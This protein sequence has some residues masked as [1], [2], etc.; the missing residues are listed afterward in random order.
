MANNCWNKVTIT[1]SNETLNKIKDRFESSE[2]GI[3]NINN[4]HILF[5]SDVSDMDEDDF[6][7][8]WFTPSVTIEDG[9]LI[10]SGDSA[11]SPM[12]GLFERICVDY[13]VEATLDYE[14]MGNDFAGRISWNSKGVEI[15]N[16]EWTYWEKEYLYNQENFWEEMQ[17]RYNNYDTFEEFIKGFELNIW[18]DSSVLNMSKLEKE[19]NLSSNT[20][21]DF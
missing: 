3:F 11:W 15:Q 14:E 9:E 5:D 1:G 16:E 19:F 7:S 2:R 21:N 20:K 17:W 8:K 10:V 18:R 13:G 6:G 12:I 4:L